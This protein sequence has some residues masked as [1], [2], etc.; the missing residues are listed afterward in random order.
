MEE[1]VEEE[2]TVCRPASAMDPDSQCELLIT[3]H[4][5]IC[6]AKVPEE[7]GEREEKIKV[8]L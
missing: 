6:N 1:E 7:G 4:K 2:A 8:S 3:S 5:L